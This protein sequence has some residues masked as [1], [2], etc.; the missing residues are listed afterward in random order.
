[1]K[2]V[3]IVVQRYGNEVVG[4]AE[5]L[6]RN[7]A[8]RLNANGFDVTVFTTAACDYVT[9]RNVY[10]PGESILRGVVIKRFRVDRE[11]DIDRFNRYSREFFSTPAKTRDEGRWIFEQGP[12]VPELVAALKK[13]QEGYDVFLFFTYL[14][15]TTVQGMPV[16]EKPIILFPTAHD[17]PPIYLESMKG[18]F[19]RP[20]ALFF[21]SAAEMEF[22]MKQFN[23]AKEMRLVRSGIDI[24]MP[25]RKDCFR[26]NFLLFAP[27][28]LYAGRMEKGKGLE[29]VFHAFDVIKKKRLVDLVLIGRQLMDIPRTPGV[30]YLGYVSESEK[31]SAF[32]HAVLSVQP[33]SL[34]SLSITTLESFSQRTPV[35]VNRKSAVLKEHVDLSGG[36]LAYD[37]ENEFID[38]FL[39]IYDH[40]L[41]RN[42]LGE[43][44]YRYLKKYY[45][46]DVVMKEIRRG[47]EQF[48]S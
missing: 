3:G 38:R 42:R 25:G 37:G 6:A 11:R 9:W 4:G 24:Q 5:T 31:A 1:M 33:S 43:N 21:L 27:F 34:E 48:I 39:Q 44:G 18:V 10:P 32:H 35:L 40:P 19:Q 41:F 29:T 47:I 45:S 8:E 46:W 12:V 13:E 7:V 14:Y 2:K 15:Y 26:D 36:G 23:P 17:E 22:V 30:R 20:D 28:I 16:I